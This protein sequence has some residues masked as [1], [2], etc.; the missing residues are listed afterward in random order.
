MGLINRNNKK[1]CLEV[2][3]EQFQRYKALYELEGWGIPRLSMNASYNM[4]HQY[5]WLRGGV[6]NGF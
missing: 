5:K 4:E 2:G 3:S 6:L 1:Y